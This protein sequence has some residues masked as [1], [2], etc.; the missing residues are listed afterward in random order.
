MSL[1][2]FVRR[3]LWGQVKGHQVFHIRVD[4]LQARFILQRL[5]CRRDR[6]LE[7]GLDGRDY[8]EGSQ[9]RVGRVYHNVG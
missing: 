4:L 8:L 7:I 5:L 1:A 2:D 9:S 6:G 3:Q